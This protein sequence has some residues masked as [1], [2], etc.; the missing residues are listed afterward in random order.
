GAWA[1]FSAARRWAG[2][3]CGSADEDVLA[4]LQIALSHFGDAPIAETER[5]RDGDRLAVGPQ[6]PDT[7]RAARVLASG[8]LSS[9]RIVPV[10]LLG[11]EHLTNLSPR[12]VA[13]LSRARFSVRRGEAGLAQEAT[14]L[15]VL[16]EDG[17]DPGNLS[18]RQAELTGESVARALTGRRRTSVGRWRFPV[19][20][21]CRRRA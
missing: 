15:A 13:K 1:S 2:C 5:H 7:P 19:R 10:T 8:G 11:R 12:L 21:A 14:L 3:R 9:E 16:R 17:I 18:F 4:F 6:D 20:L